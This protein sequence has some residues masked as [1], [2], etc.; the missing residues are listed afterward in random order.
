M[1]RQNELTSSQ[2]EKNRLNAIPLLSICIPTLNRPRFLSEALGSIASQVT[3]EIRSRIEVCVLDGGAES[4]SGVVKKFGAKSGVRVRYEHDTARIGVDRSIMR[5]A[6]MANGRFCW[7]FSDDDVIEPRAISHVVAALEKNSECAFFQ[8][9]RHIYSFDLKL[10]YP[11]FPSV[12]W[13]RAPKED[14][15]FR[16][17]NEIEEFL[18]I[19]FYDLSYMCTQVVRKDAYLEALRNEKDIGKHCTDYA[20]AYVVCRMLLEKPR[21]FYVS[22]QCVGSRMD[23]QTIFSVGLSHGGE[24]IDPIWFGRATGENFRE[25]AEAGLRGYSSSAYIAARALIAKIHLPM[26]LKTLKVSAMPF[27]KKFAVWRKVVSAYFLVPEFWIYAFPAIIIP[28]PLYFF[29]RWINRSFVKPRSATK[30]ST[31]R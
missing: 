31:N 21:A 29:L 24:V 25:V 10:C 15:A 7:F 18:G 19:F 26:Q 16:G 27:W 28:R 14:R 22:Y 6:K 3:P 1:L 5:T 23:N 20:L 2:K 17:K 13:G 12:G 30:S 4:A 11:G 8:L 9:N